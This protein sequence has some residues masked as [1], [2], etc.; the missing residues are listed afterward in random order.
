MVEEKAVD[1][2]LDLIL[3]LVWE[4]IVL[5]SVNIACRFPIKIFFHGEAL[6]LILLEFRFMSTFL[7]TNINL[8]LTTLIKRRSSDHRF[9][10]R[11]SK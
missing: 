9:Y 2:I 3:V 1:S 5:N 4:N 11:H 10:I 7:L 8:S 6:T